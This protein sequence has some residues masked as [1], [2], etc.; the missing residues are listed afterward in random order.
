VPHQRGYSCERTPDASRR[1]DIGSRRGEYCGPK[2]DFSCGVQ[3]HSGQV[4]R[5]AGPG[6]SLR[7]E[8]S[9]SRIK[10]K[11]NVTAGTERHRRVILRSIAGGEMVIAGGKNLKFADRGNR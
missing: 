7:F 1:L 2:G 8:V 6:S 4:A 3:S 9:V 5:L 10:S 11:A